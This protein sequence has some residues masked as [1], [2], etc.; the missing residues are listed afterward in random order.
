MSFLFAG[1]GEYTQFGDASALEKAK[2]KK[3]VAKTSPAPSAASSGG[4][5]PSGAVIVGAVGVL[6]VIAVVV[7][8]KMKKGRS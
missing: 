1:L 7:K 8:K 5:G 3:T 4:D 2:A 6:G